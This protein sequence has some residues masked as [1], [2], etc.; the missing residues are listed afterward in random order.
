M[1]G[2]KWHPQSQT[3]QHSSKTSVE[4]TKDI[5]TPSRVSEYVKESVNTEV[6]ANEILSHDDKEYE[7]EGVPLGS[8]RVLR[9]TSRGDVMFKPH[10]PKDFIDVDEA[11]SRSSSSSLCSSAKPNDHTWN[12]IQQANITHVVTSAGNK[13]LIHIIS[14]KATDK[15]PGLQQCATQDREDRYQASARQGKCLESLTDVA[16]DAER[17]QGLKTYS[18]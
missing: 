11:S 2:A 16:Q 9:E 14:E 10:L 7:V 17:N 8:A 18:K 5:I 1:N 3:R 12:E 6:T 4:L 15:Q 13:A